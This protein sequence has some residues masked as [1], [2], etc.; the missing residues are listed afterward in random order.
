M[1][2]ERVLIL[3][4]S[5]VLS[6]GLSRVCRE[7]ANHFHRD[8]YDVACIGWGHPNMPH[9]LPYYIYPT[10]RGSKNE[11][12][13]VLTA[14]RNF[15]PDI[16][17]C[18][19]DIWYFEYLEAVFK[20]CEHK[21]PERWLY[22]T[23]DAEPFYPDWLRILDQFTRVY[24]QSEFAKDQ[25]NLLQPARAIKTVYLGADKKVFRYI[26]RRSLWT[27]KFVV[28]VNAYNCVR[29]NIPLSIEAFAEFSAD[30]PDT[31]LFLLTQANSQEGN[32]LGRLVYWYRVQDK[33]VFE[34]NKTATSGVSD[35]MVNHYYN[36]ADCLLSTTTGEGFGLCILE[37]FLAKLPVIATAYS[38][39]PELL[40]NSR[41]IQ[42]PVA[43]YFHGTY[44]LKRAFVSKAAVV[45][46]LNTLYYDK[47]EGKTEFMEKIANNAYNF[48]KH[49]TWEKT[50][51][52]IVNWLPEKED[53]EK[54]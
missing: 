39:I 38:S 33:V 51:R 11:P 7:L 14:I 44:E 15:K 31:A 40:A 49:L 9:K 13:W 53:W 10:L 37:A 2:K 50:Y 21:I 22:L 4:D 54:C 26:D 16:F 42:L 12:S 19:G 46:A 18:I 29:K 30:K 52:E 27:D 8:S 3:S 34:R 41:G 23:L 1:A 5:P 28:M 32:N 35:E 36:N 43:A 24:T 48:A 20:K 6:G 47:K 17:I 45:T 25:I